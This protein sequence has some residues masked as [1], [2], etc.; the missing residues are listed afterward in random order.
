MNGPGSTNR[1]PAGTFPPYPRGGVG[2]GKVEVPWSNEAILSWSGAAPANGNSQTNGRFAEWSAPIFDLRPEYK[3]PAQF[4][5]GTQG[6][7]PI[8]DAQ[9][10]QLVVQVV[11]LPPA[12][13]NPAAG[14]DTFLEG[15]NISVWD[16]ANPWNPQDMRIVT[17]EQDVTSTFTSSSELHGKGPIT[18]AQG[19]GGVTVF[20]PPTGPA[21]PVRYWRPRMIFRFHLQ[22]PFDPRVSVTAGYY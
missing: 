13:P 7:V 11:F 6:C 10:K 1:G 15:L 3:G 12:S 22:Q 8:Y 20:A 19:I 2:D 9:S 14:V 5:P 21:G 16:E 17:A 18:S 4:N